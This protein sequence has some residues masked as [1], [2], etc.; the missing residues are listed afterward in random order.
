MG[1]EIINRRQAR[2]D[3]GEKDKNDDP[4]FVKS[5]IELHEKYLGVVKKDFSGH[6]LF[7]KALKDAFVDFVNK[8]IG[9][10]TNA[11]LMSTFCDSILKSGGEKLSEQEVEESLVRIFQLFFYLT[12]KDLFAEIYRNQLDKRSLNKRSTSDDS[13][14]LMIAKL[15][16]QC[17]TQFTSKMEVMLPIWLSAANSGPNLNNACDRLTPSWTLVSKYTVRV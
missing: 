2:L 5:I 8:N 7:Q 4:K 6:S 10:F 1:H 14:K 16:V 17:G 15:K 9:Q 12:G 13:E 11:E 3:G